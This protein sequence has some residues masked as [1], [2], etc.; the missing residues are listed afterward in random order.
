MLCGEGLGVIKLCVDLYLGKFFWS[1]VVIRVSFIDIDRAVNCIVGK[2]LG[3][4]WVIEWNTSFYIL[5]GFEKV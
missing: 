2:V 5:W 4:R 1:R 3:E